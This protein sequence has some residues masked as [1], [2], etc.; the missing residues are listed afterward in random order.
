MQI[1]HENNPLNESDH[2]VDIEASEYSK[3][4]KS[5]KSIESA[6]RSSKVLHIKHNYH[7][8]HPHQTIYNQV[9]LQYH[10]NLIN[11]VK[12]TKERS[13]HNRSNSNS[14]IKRKRTKFSNISISKIKN[15]CLQQKDAL[16]LAHGP[17]TAKSS[18]QKSRKS[19]IE[20]KI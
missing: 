14:K 3:L 8:P 17:S 19:S 10:H 13:I 11:P 6:D 1:S 9:N 7:N 12:T 15:N 18:Q 20:M 5:N 16:L 2:S 4:N